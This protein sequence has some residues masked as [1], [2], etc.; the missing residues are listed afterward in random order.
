MSLD[1]YDQYANL[2]S[3]HQFRFTPPV[4]CILAFDRALDEL[5]AEG[6]PSGRMVRYANNHRI[7][8][9]TLVGRLGFRELVPI[10]E[11]SRVINTFFYPKD[12]HFE[13]E[14]FYTKLSERGKVIYPGKVTKAPCFRIGNIGDLHEKDMISLCEDIE[15]V[16]NEMNV[17]LPITN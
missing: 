13:F 17:A 5:V 11:Q 8:R 3:T 6:G 4:H 7:V 1:L 9:D 15:I 10:D 12:V 16:L 14:K 2:M